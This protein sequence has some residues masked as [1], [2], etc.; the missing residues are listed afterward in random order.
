[1]EIFLVSK[2]IAIC[3]LIL[4]ACSTSI[5]Q[6]SA[7]NEAMVIGANINGKNVEVGA[8][9]DVLLEFN[10]TQPWCGLD[11]QWGD[12][13]EETVRVG[14]EKFNKFPLRLSH[15]YQAPGQFTLKIVGKQITRGLRSASPCLGLP[16][17]T[18][19]MVE[20]AQ[21][22]AEAERSRI[23]A[24]RTKEEVGRRTRELEEKEAELRRREE[25]LE[26]D[27]KAQ[28]RRDQEHKANSTSTPT[29]PIQQPVPVKKPTIDPF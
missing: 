24:N 9:V 26:R 27:R 23:E 21:Q 19:V 13:Q 28:D 25:K 4:L 7:S 17:Q 6:E 29:L 11:I 8:P 3:T 12:G 18:I 14:H 2:H 16:M 1:M 10:V 5:A 22:K 15:A 20:S